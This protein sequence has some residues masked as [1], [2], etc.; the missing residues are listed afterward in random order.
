MSQVEAASGVAKSNI[1]RLEKGG[2]MNL[3][4]VLKIL[5]ALNVRIETVIYA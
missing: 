1:C 4:N 5:N 2:E 3:S